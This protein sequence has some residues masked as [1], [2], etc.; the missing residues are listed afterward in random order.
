MLAVLTAGLPNI[1][2]SYY[3]HVACDGNTDINVQGAFADSHLLGSSKVDYTSGI[4]DFIC[5]F[6][7]SNSN[8]IYGASTTVQPPAIVL[9]LQ[10]RY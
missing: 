5:D 2:G 10:I 8:N 7:A 6:N 4:G 9:I 1:M 3:L